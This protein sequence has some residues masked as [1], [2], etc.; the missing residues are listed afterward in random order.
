MTD[1]RLALIA[2]LRDSLPQM[3]AI[4]CV[5]L[6]VALI[7]SLADDGVYLATGAPEE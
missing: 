3:N 4:A 7:A 6:A 1:P 2:A 5:H